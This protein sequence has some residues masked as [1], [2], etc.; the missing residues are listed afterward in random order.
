MSPNGCLIKGALVTSSWWERGFLTAPIDN[1]PAPAGVL[2]FS[3]IQTLSTLRLSTQFPLVKG[4]VPQDHA[5]FQMPMANPDC[6]LYLWLMEYK[7]EVPRTPSFGLINLMEWLTKLRKPR[8]NL[9]QRIQP[10]TSQTKEMPRA[11]HEENAWSHSVL[12][13]GNALPIS[14]CV[15]QAR[16]SP[17]PTLLGLGE[18]SLHWHNEL[19]H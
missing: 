1:S 14:P 19:H 17:N 15:H 7:S 18:A 6:Y 13:K 8:T 5:L 4:S 2:P 12:P 10:R 16:S 11:R 9:L 3:S